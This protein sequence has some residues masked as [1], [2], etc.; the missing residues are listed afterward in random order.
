MGKSLGEDISR[1]SFRIKEGHENITKVSS[2][3]I[4]SD[5]NSIQNMNEKSKRSVQ[6]PTE[7][8]QENSQRSVTKNGSLGKNTE[9][10]IENYNERSRFTGENNE[11]KKRSLSEKSDNS[12]LVKSF[13]N[14]RN[15]FDF[16]KMK[17]QKSV[18]NVENELESF[19]YKVK[20]NY[21]PKRDT[22]KSY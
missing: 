22:S 5:Q 17:S 3:N 20:K 14:T 2:R 16:N 1:R 8:I 13:C 6:R 12:G 21:N 4:E 10:H 19:E 15:S 11:Y 7:N 9:N 18:Q